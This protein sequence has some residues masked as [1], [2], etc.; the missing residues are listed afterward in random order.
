MAKKT[1]RFIYWTPRV[2]SILFLVYL[3]LMSLDIF[4]GYYGFWGMVLGLFHAQHPNI[5]TACYTDNI[6]EA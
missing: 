4:D 5:D 3:A 1:R 2:L 6:L